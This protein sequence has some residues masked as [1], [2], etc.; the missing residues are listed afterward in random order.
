MF[1]TFQRR[2]CNKIVNDFDLITEVKSDHVFLFHD[3]GTW[4][5]LGIERVNALLTWR[6]C[7]STKRKNPMAHF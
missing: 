3:W 6:A 7:W 5:E 1:V 2:Q 4:K